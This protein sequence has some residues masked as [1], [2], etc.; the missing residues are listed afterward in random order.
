MQGDVDSETD[1]ESQRRV[2]DYCGAHPEMKEKFQKHPEP[3]DSF[4]AS[5]RLTEV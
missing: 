2:G 5:G 4:I 1:F 3:C